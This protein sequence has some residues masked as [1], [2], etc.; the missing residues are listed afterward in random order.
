VSHESPDELEARLFASARGEHASNRVREQTLARML[1]KRRQSRRAFRAAALVTVLA[2]AAV[3]SLFAYVTQQPEPIS[4]ERLPPGITPSST[5]ALVR[6]PLV[7]LTPMPDLPRVPERSASRTPPSAASQPAA[8]PRSNAAPPSLEEE[9]R[10]LQTVQAELRAGRA[11]RALTALD[12]YERATR[13]GHLAAEARILRIQALAASGR[14]GE[15][16]KLAERFLAAYPNSPLGD[17][18]RKY[19][20]ATGLGGNGTNGDSGR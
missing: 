19:L 2:A 8:R 16:A 10:A 7:P 3:V 18:A 11:Q 15:A 13:N 20:V 17:R 9:T 14:S 6:E 1:Q 12:D 4:A 5:A